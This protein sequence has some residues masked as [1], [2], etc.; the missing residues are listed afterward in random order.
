MNNHD[1]LRRIGQ[2]LYWVAKTLQ[3]MALFMF[4]GGFIG[5]AAMF[6]LAALDISVVANAPPT[7]SQSIGNDTIDTVAVL[8]LVVSLLYELR[9]LGMLAEVGKL[10]TTGEFLTDSLADHWWR[11]SRS[12]TISGVVKLLAPRQAFNCNNGA[13]VKYD[14]FPDVGNI[15]YLLITVL[16]CYTIA[17]ILREAARTKHE[18]VAVKQEND[19]FI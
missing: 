6:G 7:A 14:Y 17:F 10:L 13:D 16:C 11:F 3:M 9:A 19:G 2:W 4:L 1:S 8:M 18:A 5:M 12:I 15:Q